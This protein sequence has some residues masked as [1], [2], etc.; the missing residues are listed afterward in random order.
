[1][2]V[3]LKARYLVLEE[4]KR[5]AKMMSFLVKHSSAADADETT[6]TG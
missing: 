4:L 5:F 1:M 6:R 3:L 2:R